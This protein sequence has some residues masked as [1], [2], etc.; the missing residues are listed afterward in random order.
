MSFT[1]VVSNFYWR[2]YA[3]L[4]FVVRRSSKMKA[5]GRHDWFQFLSQT[6]TNPMQ[7]FSFGKNKLLLFLVR[8][9]TPLGISFLAAALDFNVFFW[10]KQLGLKSRTTKTL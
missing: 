2:C 7:D 3:R 10:Y 8:D 6:N 9:T 4:L 1:A 5:L